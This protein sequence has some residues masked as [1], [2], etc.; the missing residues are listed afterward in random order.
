MKPLRFAKAHEDVSKDRENPWLL[1][2]SD[3]KLTVKNKMSLSCRRKEK[4]FKFFPSE[5]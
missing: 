5:V 2:G 3:Y 4:F 1:H